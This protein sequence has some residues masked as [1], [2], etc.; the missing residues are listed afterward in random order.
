MAH[1]TKNSR[2]SG[3]AGPNSL[4]FL[5]CGSQ[6]LHTYLFSMEFGRRKRA[7]LPHSFYKSSGTSYD[8]VWLGHVTTVARDVAGP[9]L[10]CVVSLETSPIS[11]PT[12]YTNYLH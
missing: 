2:G 11:F 12:L 9:G 5:N 10:G 3:K 8:W 6:Y 1:K 4:I 7:P